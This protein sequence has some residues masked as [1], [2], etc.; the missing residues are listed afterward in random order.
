MI[1][2]CKNKLTMEYK[3]KTKKDANINNNNNIIIRCVLL[4]KQNQSRSIGS[5]QNIMDIKSV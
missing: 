1:L 4:C 3:K 2:W 5:K